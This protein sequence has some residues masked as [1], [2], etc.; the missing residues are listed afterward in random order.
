MNGNIKLSDSNKNL[1]YLRLPINLTDISIADETE[2]LS[3]L[4]SSGSE[5]SQP[6]RMG[7]WC[8]LV[9][10]RGCISD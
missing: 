3:G 1:L 6:G 8:T 2:Q 9:E 7:H 4:V 5:V 10:Q